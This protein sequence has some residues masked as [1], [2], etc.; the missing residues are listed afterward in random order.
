VLTY[1]STF[2]GIGGFDWGFDRAGMEC[3]WMVEKDPKCQAL[4]RSK[5]P[6]TPII[7]DICIAGK[8][9]LQPTDVI[10]GGSPCQDLSVAGRR[11]GLDGERSGLYF[12]LHRVITEL[13]PSWIV[14]EN[15]PGIFSSNGGRDF[16]VVLG[17]F[18]GVIPAVPEN[19]WRNAG[20]ATGPFYKVAWR[21]L[22][23]QFYGVA[24]R[25][26]RLFIV[27][28]LRDGRAAEVLFEPEV[29]SWDP[30]SGRAAGEEVA[31]TL[32]GGAQRRG[33]P[34]D[35]DRAGA[36]IAGTVT[37]KW[38]KGTGGP[39]GDEC[40]NL[41]AHTLRSAGADASEDGTG[42]GTPLVVQRPTAAYPILEVGARTGV[43]TEDV[44]CGAGIGDD[45]APMFTLQSSKQ[46][47]VGYQQNMIGD[48][49]PT[50]EQA[51]TLRTNANRSSQFIH[52]GI[53]VRRLM[54]VECEKLQGFDPGHTAGQSDSARYAQLGNAVTVNVA[55][56]IGRRIVRAHQRS[57]NL[58]EQSQ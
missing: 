48:I 49:S 2:T 43:S 4:L 5:K 58:T 1:G 16:A 21:V 34:D 42:R 26:R 27:G 53:S 54:P 28:H 56:W 40:Q 9:C 37:S 31:G 17:G 52:G 36:F 57:A 3:L 32:G 11:K 13:W 55:E 7:H 50:G 45:G 33:W 12:E 14:F 30:P 15:V 8:H 23:S 51:G 35:R 6:N 24:Q 29:L 18:T 39:A 10:C 19:G 46:H 25:R 44:R 41:V 20:F 38:K 47:A 22:D